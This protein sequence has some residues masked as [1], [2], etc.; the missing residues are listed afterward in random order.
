MDLESDRMATFDDFVAVHAHA[1]GLPVSWPGYDF[2]PATVPG[3]AR[4]DDAPTDNLYLRVNT[5]IAPP[6]VRGIGDGWTIY[7]WTLQVDVCI[8]DGIGE[9]HAVRE[10]QALRSALPK[11]HSLTGAM[12][13][14]TVPAPA[15]IS[16]SLP[17]DGW[18]SMPVSIR[19]QTIL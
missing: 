18:R 11:N 14:F 12:H 16:T 6:D 3:N 15:A 8:R 10:A 1:R 5:L 4:L 2:D 7:L 9:T 13:D 19:L 17:D